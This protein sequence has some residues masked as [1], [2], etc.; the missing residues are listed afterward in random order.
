[1]SLLRAESPGSSAGKHTCIRVGGSTFASILASVFHLGQ[2]VKEFFSTQVH[3]EGK[4][5]QA[6]GA[7][8]KRECLRAVRKL[9]G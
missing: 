8:K 9:A 6:A 2:T 7:E 5:A 4:E 3:R 1:M